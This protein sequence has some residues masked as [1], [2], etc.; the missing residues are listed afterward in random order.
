MLFGAAH[1]GAATAAERGAAGEAGGRGSLSDRVGS[2]NTRELCADTLALMGWRQPGFDW[3]CVFITEV[4]LRIDHL[5]QGNFHQFSLI[6]HLQVQLSETQ[7]KVALRAALQEKQRLQVGGPRGERMPPSST[8][9]NYPH[10]NIGLLFIRK[11]AVHTWF[12]QTL[13][14]TGHLGGGREAA[15]ISTAGG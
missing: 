6:C 1:R 10:P 3:L 13:C 5:S 11:Y 14:N 7:A 8:P 12:I 15:G 2:G 4:L 9:M